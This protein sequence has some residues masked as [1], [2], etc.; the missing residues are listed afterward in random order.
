MNN[1]TIYLIVF[2]IACTGYIF[3]KVNMKEGF[4]YNPIMKPKCLDCYYKNTNECNSCKNCGICKRG[5]FASCVPGNSNG[6]TFNE[7]CQ[8]YVYNIQDKHINSIPWKW[9]PQ[10]ETWNISNPINL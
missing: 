8:E 7:D 5:K 4:S 2:V 9:S 10:A 1:L 3:L 6:P